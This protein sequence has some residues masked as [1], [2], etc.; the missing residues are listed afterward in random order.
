MTVIKILSGET[1]A[2]FKFIVKMD[3][4][5]EPHTDKGKKRTPM[6]LSSHD[7]HG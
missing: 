1:V 2:K 7:Y 4:Q 6:S 5:A 3:R